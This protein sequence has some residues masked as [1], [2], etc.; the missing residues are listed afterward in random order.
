MFSGFNT[1]HVYKTFDGGS[2][3]QV[4]DGGLPDVPTNTIVVDPEYPELVYVGNDLGVYVSMDGGGFWEVFSEGLPEAV[5]AFHLSISPSNR[6]LRV[7]THGNGVYETDLLEEIL[8]NTE[9]LIATDFVTLRNYPN[10]VI[11]ETTFEF[12]LKERATVSLTLIDISG[13]IIKTLLQ[14]VE[15]LDSKQVRIN[16][17]DLPAGVYAYRL[18]GKTMSKGQTFSIAKTLIKN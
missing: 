6:K 15:V 16:L 2:S 13:K 8:E 7:G 12:D 11:S 1:N 9:E 17:G 3:W 10:P 18:E 4:V 5:I 14:N